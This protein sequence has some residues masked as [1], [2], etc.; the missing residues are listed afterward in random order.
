M[1][2]RRGTVMDARVREGGRR[3]VEGEGGL[4]TGRERGKRNRDREKGGR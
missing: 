1:G 2:R 4:E 3:E